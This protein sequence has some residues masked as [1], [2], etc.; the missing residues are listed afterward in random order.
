M[1]FVW[2]RY[3]MGIVI[4]RRE[5]VKEKGVMHSEQVQNPARQ[6]HWILQL[7]NFPFQ[8]DVLFSGP[9][10]VAT[11]LLLCRATPPFSLVGCH[12]WGTRCGEPWPQKQK[13]PPYLLKS[14]PAPG[15][16]WGKQCYDLWIPFRLALPFLKEWCTFIAEEPYGL[17]L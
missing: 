4:P 17:V 6:I 10:G 1:C 9:T 3:K 13:K 2:G 15:P 11:P 16:W 12:P 7:E 14:S 5:I 8:L